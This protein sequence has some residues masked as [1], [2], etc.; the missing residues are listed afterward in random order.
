VRILFAHHILDVCICLVDFR[1]CSLVVILAHSCDAQFI[2]SK[3]KWR[4]DMPDDILRDAIE[5]SRTILD[6][7]DF[8]TQG[9]STNRSS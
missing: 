2:H 4:C 8:E 6:S 3:V 5:T 7:A 1:A 9:Q